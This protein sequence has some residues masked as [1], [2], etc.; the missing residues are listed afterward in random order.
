MQPLFLCFVAHLR[1]GCLAGHRRVELAHG[2][3]HFCCKGK[4][5]FEGAVYVLHKG[6]EEV[7]GLAEGFGY[8]GVY[9]SVV[10]KGPFFTFGYGYVY[11]CIYLKGVAQYVFLWVQ[12]MRGLYTDAM[13]RNGKHAQK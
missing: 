10:G 5:F 2:Y 8:Y 13:Q 4:F 3:A 7:A 6:F 11:I 9:D 1:V 12:P